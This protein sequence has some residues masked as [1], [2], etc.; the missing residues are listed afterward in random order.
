MIIIDVE[1]YTNYFLLSALHLPTGKILHFEKHNDSELD[2]KP[3]KA[4]LNKNTTVSFNGFSYDLPVIAQA[5]TGAT[6]AELKRTSDNIIKSNLPSWKITQQ[7]GIKVPRSWDHIDLI[8]VAPGKNGLKIY[9]GR[10]GAPKMQDLPIEPSAIISVE[11]ATELRSYCEN[12][13]YTTERLYRKLEKQMDLRVAMS[14]QYG[15]DLRSKSDAQIAETV[16]KSELSKLTGKTYR[17][18]DLG[19][20]YGF[21]YQDP[22]IIEFKTEQMQ[23]IF[24]RLLQTRFELGANGAVQMPEWLKKDKI[25]IGSGAYQ[26]GIGGLHSCEK[27]RCVR[28]QEGE[29]LADLDVASYYPNIILQQ[30]LAP[31][32]LG[33]PFLKVYQSLVDRRIKAKKRSQEI[34]KEITRLEKILAKLT[35]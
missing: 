6:N 14:D 5:L 33:V 10:L 1:C 11:Q 18:P 28:R 8:E 17:S 22:G 35:V 29:I 25:V 27:K 31:E 16:I 21:T 19:D 30:R 13:L 26:M 32:S 24:Q 20:D 23:S 34:V 4:M 9:G 3:I 2:I 15:V 12:D 7:L